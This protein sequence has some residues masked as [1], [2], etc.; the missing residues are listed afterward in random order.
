MTRQE[1]IEA[2]EACIANS[3]QACPLFTKW[4]ENCNQQLLAAI[5]ELA[6]GIE[7]KCS[8]PQVR[9]EYGRGL[10]LQVTLQDEGKLAGQELSDGY[11]GGYLILRA[12]RG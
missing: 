12:Q 1:I 5:K 2:S 8:D 7:I 9:H 10:V 6:N 4:N 11:V 3:C